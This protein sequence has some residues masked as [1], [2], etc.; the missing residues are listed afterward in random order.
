MK[1]LTRLQIVLILGTLGFFLPI[2]CSSTP[3]NKTASGKVSG[4]DEQIFIGDTVEKNY[5]PNV[6]MKRA[7][8]FYDKEEYPEAIIEYQHFL[9]L[10]RVH[11]LA[12]YAQFRLGES[13]FKMIKTIDRDL[14]PVRKSLEAYEKLLKDYPGNKYQ[15]ETRERIHACHDFL[16][17]GNYF[18]G[19]FYY[20][21]E[22]YLAAAHRFESIVKQYPE[23]EV[24]SDAMYDL[25]RTYHEIGA[26]D[27]AQEKLLALEQQ[28]PNHKHKTE[29]Q[30]LYAKLKLTEPTTAIARGPAPT[31]GATALAAA[32]FSAASLAAAPVMTAA[33]GASGEPSVKGSSGAATTFSDGLYR[34]RPS[35]L[36]S[37]PKPTFTVASAKGVPSIPN[38]TAASALTDTSTAVIPHTLCRLGAWC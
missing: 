13:H 18:V 11:T 27:W 36:P 37:S 21:R 16:A 9:D 30:K 5:D 7:E 31:N 24:A 8:A 26:D 4:T 33:R 38:V 34:G 3:K 14:D 20:R 10:H 15:A 6:I 19:Q 17:Q 32:D 28:Y 29:S 2:A 1:L 12:P 25:A 22:A 35:S 23:M